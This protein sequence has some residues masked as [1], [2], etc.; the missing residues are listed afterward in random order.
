MELVQNLRFHKIIISRHNF[1]EDSL[2]NSLLV[3]ISIWINKL[4]HHTTQ[5][6]KTF[7]V[8]YKF[9]P[10]SSEEKDKS[11]NEWNKLK[12]TLP[13]GI[14][15]IGEYTLSCNATFNI[16]QI[17]GS[18]STIKIDLYNDEEDEQ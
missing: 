12:N 13:E 5:H 14:E 4:I 3:S 7:L 10:M 6:G 18:S 16:S 1:I 8:F 11:N 17:S 15:L 9:R 2:E